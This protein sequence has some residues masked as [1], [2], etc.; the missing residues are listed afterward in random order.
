MINRGFFIW[1][2][3]ITCKTTRSECNEY[4]LANQFRLWRRVVNLP[5]RESHLAPYMGQDGEYWVLHCKNHFS[6]SILII[7]TLNDRA[8]YSTVCMLICVRFKSCERNTNYPI[9]HHIEE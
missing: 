8:L 1:S 4:R 7:V 3:T 2:N 5:L 9:Y 6:L